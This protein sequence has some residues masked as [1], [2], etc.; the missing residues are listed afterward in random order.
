MGFNDE[1]SRDAYLPEDV[2]PEY[3]DDPDD[4]FDDFTQEDWEDWFSET[5]LDDWMSIRESYESQYLEAPGS[6][7]D[8]CNFIYNSI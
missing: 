7:N 3:I 5:L 4:Q 1:Y 6:F 8:Y 2:G